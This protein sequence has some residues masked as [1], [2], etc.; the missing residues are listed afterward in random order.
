MR[1]DSTSCGLFTQKKTHP[2]ITP[3][4][5]HPTPVRPAAKGAGAAHERGAADASTAREG[6]TAAGESLF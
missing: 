3:P 2:L 6:Q 4:T 5:Q 1:A